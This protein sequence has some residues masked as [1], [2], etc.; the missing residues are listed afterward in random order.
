MEAGQRLPGEGGR[1]TQISCRCQVRWLD[2][3]SQAWG[4]GWSLTWWGVFNDCWRGVFAVFNSPREI[5]SRVNPIVRSQCHVSKMMSQKSDS[6]WC[7]TLPN[8]HH[9]LR[10]HAK[11]PIMPIIPSGLARA[12]TPEST[13]CH[14]SIFLILQ[15]LCAFVK[16]A[17]CKKKQFLKEDWRCFGSRV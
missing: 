16:R 15:K 3:S 7:L 9:Q 12:S 14:L 13:S 8:N 5:L 10:V 2:F 1:L 6:R 11:R 17:F 4:R